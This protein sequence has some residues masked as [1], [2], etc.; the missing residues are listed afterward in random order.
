MEKEA[1]VLHVVICVG[2]PALAAVTSLTVTVAVA[3][4]QGGVPLTV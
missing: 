1:A 4:G 3:F 2:Q